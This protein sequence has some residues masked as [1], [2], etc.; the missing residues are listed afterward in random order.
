LFDE[1]AGRSLKSKNKAELFA[2]GDKDLVGDCAE[3]DEQD[4]ELTPEVSP[5]C[6]EDE[7]D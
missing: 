4:E 5:S 3:T 7:V 1:F 2:V 6:I